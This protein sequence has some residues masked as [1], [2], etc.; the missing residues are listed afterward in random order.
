M[1]Y[2]CKNMLKLYYDA[3]M[4]DIRESK[5]IF[6][7]DGGAGKTHTIKRILNA[8]IDECIDTR[9]TL[10]ICIS[11]YHAMGKDGEFTINF[12]DFGGQENMHSMHRCF[13]TERTCYVVV[14][15]NRWNLDVQARYWLNNIQSFAPKAPVILAVNKWDGIAACPMDTNRLHRDFPNLEEITYYTAKGGD[16]EDFRTHLTK[17]IV[18]HA[19]ELDS[20]AMQLPVEWA[21]IRQE[22]VDMAGSDQ[23][24]I[25]QR[26]Y[27][28]ICEKHGLGG[29]ENA[30]IRTWLLDWFNDLGI[31]FSHHENQSQYNVLNPRWLTSGIYVLLNSNPKYSSNGI[32]SAGSIDALLRTPTMDML[33][34]P[35]AG[36][37]LPDYILC[38]DVYD[39]K[40]N[41]IREPLSY[42]KDEQQHILAI[43][44]KFELSYP[45][46]DNEEFIPALCDSNMP[47]ELHPT[48]YA[49]RISYE[50]RYSFLPDSVVQRLMVRMRRTHQFSALWRRGFRFEETNLT[51]VVDAGGGKDTLR[52]DIFAEKDSGSKDTLMQLA[53]Q[54]RDIQQAMNMTAEEYIIVHG[55]RGEIPVPAE[56]VLEAWQ[57]K[58]PQLYLY[59]KE[60]GLIPKDVHEILGETYSQAVLKQAL[61]IAS[62]QRC[63]VSDAMTKVIKTYHIHI[64]DNVTGKKIEGDYYD[65]VTPKNLLAVLKEFDQK[66]SHNEEL[67]THVLNE[68]KKTKDEKAEALVAEM[69]AD[70]EKKPKLFERLSGMVSGMV[71]TLADAPEAVKTV[72]AIAAA[73]NTAVQLYGPQILNALENLQ[74]NFP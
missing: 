8:D 48:E 21:A 34:V 69:T 61:Q 57:R 16:T 12:W 66:Y 60:N 63:S 65:H 4:V 2:Q 31:C 43:M 72:A 51:V 1:F 11:P 55:R 39:R 71:S 29:G 32:M 70:T 45:V 22:L 6:L 5:V 27:E 25:D 73:V 74:R 28:H 23:W 9:T 35:A 62:N 56:M 36:D 40:G 33:C 49:S 42:S 52:I 44:R 18:R 24:Y 50:F 15:S 38:E 67:L 59:S 46:S 17:F 7:G 20:N 54:I 37:D 53:A 47:E 26:G 3:K 64:G 14:I 19:E 58:I 10:G 13:L 30:N 68:L 41:L